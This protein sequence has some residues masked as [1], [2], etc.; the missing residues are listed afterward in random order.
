MSV[1]M[2]SMERSQQASL[3]SRDALLAEAHTL[4]MTVAALRR[5]RGK[6]NPQDISVDSPEWHEIAEDFARD[7]LCALRGDSA[8]HDDTQCWTLGQR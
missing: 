6:P 1:V 7:V 8:G 3:D 4:A 2:S 5:A